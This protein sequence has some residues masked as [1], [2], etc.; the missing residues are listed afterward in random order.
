M[1]KF[2]R[3]ALPGAEPLACWTRHQFAATCRNSATRAIL[4]GE[5]RTRRRKVGLALKGGADAFSRG[6][7]GALSAFDHREYL[8]G[9]AKHALE[10]FE[11]RLASRR[12]EPAGAE[13]VEG[14]GGG[15]DVG[16]RCAH[17]AMFAFEVFYY[18]Q[19]FGSVR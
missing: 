3:G 4:L 18:R 2:R 9:E 12:D 10:S 17:Q 8:C 11:P 15:G 14:G 7:T 19:Q 16:G 1:S 6:S 5:V 13:G